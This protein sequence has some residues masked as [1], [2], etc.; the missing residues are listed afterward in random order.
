MQFQPEFRQF[1]GQL[2][3]CGRGFFSSNER[4]RVATFLTCGDTEKKD[5]FSV[6]NKEK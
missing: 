6:R 1:D 5:I 3:V 4:R 2:R